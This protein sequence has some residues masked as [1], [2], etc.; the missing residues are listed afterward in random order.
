MVEL[1]QIAD[2]LSNAVLTLLL[3]AHFLQVSSCILIGLDLIGL[4]IEKFIPNNSSV[5]FLKIEKVKGDAGW[6]GGGAW[7][8]GRV[9]VVV[10]GVT[11][12]WQLE[13]M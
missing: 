4:R 9:C 2:L 13:T 7:G 8:W 3:L 1:D 5:Q 6:Q 10:G 11:I 12:K